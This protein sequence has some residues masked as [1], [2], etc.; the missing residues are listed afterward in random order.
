[1]ISFNLK[2]VLTMQQKSG[3]EMGREQVLTQFGWQDAVELAMIVTAI[4]AFV[5]FR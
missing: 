4:L 3:S 5:L 2:K 1:M